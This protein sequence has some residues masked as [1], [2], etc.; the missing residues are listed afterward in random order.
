MQSTSNRDVSKPVRVLYVGAECKPFSMVGGVGDVVGE[1]P[2]ALH[3]DGYD[4]QIVTPGY[5]SIDPK[6]IDS[7][8]HETA[9][10]DFK[11]DGSSRLSDGEA[12][13]VHYKMGNLGG[14]PVHFVVNDTYFGTRVDSRYGKPYVDSVDSPFKDDALR[15]SFFAKAVLPLIKKHKPDIVHVNDWTMGYLLGW[16]KVNGLL[17]AKDGPATVLTIHNIGYQGNMRRDQI[18]GWDIEALANHSSTAELFADPHADWNNINPLRLGMELAD[19][20]NTVSPTYMREMMQAEDQ[21]RFFEGGKGLE[22]TARTLHSQQRLF[23]ILNGIQYENSEP[24][25]AAFATVMQKK[26]EMRTRFAAYFKQP[27]D[28]LVGFVGRCVDQKFKLLSEY[29]DLDDKKKT[30]LEHILDIPGVNVA[31]LA[32]GEAKYESF[33]SNIGVTAYG[34]SRSYREVLLAGRRGNYVSTVAFDRDR[35]LQTWLASDLFLMPSLFEPCGITQLQSMERATPPLVRG[36]GGLVDTVID[37]AQSGSTGFVCDGT[38]RDAVLQSIINGVLKAKDLKDNHPDR[39]LEMQ[40][41]AFNQRFTWERALPEY[42][43]LYKAA[44]SRRRRDDA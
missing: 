10:L 33:M 16:M 2:V 28:F 32:T 30:V 13:T 3:S 21:S 7:S 14:V 35:A 15:F 18:A 38:S 42:S 39:F 25:D 31:F 43:A 27:S 8:R 4:V 6:H 44:L 37:Y 36:T 19:V 40:R 20:T 34:D 22:G 17:D 24:S 41:R 12:R 5:S 26:A 23:G 9:C 29:L 1:M 11:V